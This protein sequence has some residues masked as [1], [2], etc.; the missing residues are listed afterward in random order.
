ME[1]KAAV[2]EE[3]TK[4]VDKETI[5]DIGG[6]VLP[7]SNLRDDLNIDS[8]EEIEI[9]MTLEKRFSIYVPDEKAEEIK[10]VGD[11]IILIEEGLKK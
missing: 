3:I 5:D 11:V 4:F 2:I 9:V 10:T 7:E 1:I 6:A 8:L